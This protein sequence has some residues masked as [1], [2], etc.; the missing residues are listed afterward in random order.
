M[1][2]SRNSAVLLHQS[3]CV[4]SDSYIII[5]GAAQS[6]LFPLQSLAELLFLIC[7]NI[8][9]SIKFI[10]A[11]MAAFSLSFTDVCVIF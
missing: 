8:F 4:Q 6:H 2:V 1:K 7:Q 5:T 10:R 11:R 9:F 3:C